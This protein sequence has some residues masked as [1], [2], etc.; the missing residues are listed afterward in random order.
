MAKEGKKNKAQPGRARNQ[1][2]D[3]SSGRF[4]RASAA[5]GTGASV[6]G[7]PPGEAAAGVE[8]MVPDVPPG[9]EMVNPKGAAGTVDIGHDVPLG[10]ETVT[11]KGAAG[12]SSSSAVHKVQSLAFSVHIGELL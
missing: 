3:P 1:R 2:R 12:S 11:P 5:S 6:E 7:V 4:T 8:N 9:F 10:F